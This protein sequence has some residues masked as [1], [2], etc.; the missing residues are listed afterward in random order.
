MSRR[1]EREGT[2]MLGDLLRQHRQRLGLSQEELAERVTPAL[3]VTTIGNIERGRTRPYR[4]QDAPER[5]QTLR[6][7][8][9]W[10]YELLPE[11]EQALFRRLSVFAGGCTLEAAEAVCTDSDGA[12]SPS[13]VS[14]LD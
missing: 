9:A 3:S 6:A 10:S 1:A 11:A 8:I 2:G 13:E 5:H 7:T 4:P 12:A 14:I